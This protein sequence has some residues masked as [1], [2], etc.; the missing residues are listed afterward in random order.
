MSTPLLNTLDFEIETKP[1]FIE[2]EFNPDHKAITN[3]RTGAFIG[4][5]GKHYSPITNEAFMKL[6]GELQKTGL[7]AIKGYDKLKDGKLVLGFL[8]YQEQNLSINGCGFNEHL[9]LINSHD[10]SRPFYAGSTNTLARCENQFFSSIKIIRKKHTSP[11]VINEFLVHEIVSSY[12]RGRSG[13][14][15]K[16]E[17]L[18]KIKVDDSVVEELIKD[19]YTRLYWDSSMPKPTEKIDSP[20]MNLLRQC[21]YKEMGDIGRNAFGLFNGVTWYTSHEMRNSDRHFGNTGGMANQLNQRA[22]QFVSK[23]KLINQ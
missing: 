14:N 1:V 3:K 2:N 6:A 15:K 8:E 13:I 17:S 21:I 16:L 5:V 23:L 12:K 9:V 20:S 18:D 7:F 19:L 10:G 4:M 22:F 11:L